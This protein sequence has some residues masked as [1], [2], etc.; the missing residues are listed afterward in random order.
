MNDDNCSINEFPQQQIHIQQSRY[1]WTITMEMMFSMWFVL[2]RYKQNQLRTGH[3]AKLRELR[4]GSSL[5]LCKRLIRDGTTAHVTV[6]S[7][8]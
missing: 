3:Y 8:N 4:V 6:E 7:E 5:E 2:K 1:C